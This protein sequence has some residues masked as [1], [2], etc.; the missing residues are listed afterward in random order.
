MRNHWLMGATALA[1]SL[2]LVAGCGSK[3]TTSTGT[4]TTGGAAQKG[5]VLKVAIVGEPPT[6]DMHTTT[7]T[8]AFE[9]GWHIFETLYTYTADYGI[10]PMLAE[11]LPEVKADGKI[12]VIKLR[13][14]VPFHNGKVMTSDDVVASINRWNKLAQNAKG[15]MA[16]LKAV[17]APDKNTVQF[18][19]DKPNGTLLAALATPGNGLAIYPKEI[20]D[21]YPDKP[22][23]EFIGTGPYKLIEH[24]PDR[25]YKLQRFDQY[26]S[27]SEE[28]NGP[29]GKKLAV[30]DE[31]QFIPVPDTNTRLSGLES[32]EYDVAALLS[33]SQYQSVKNDSS[34]QAIVV[35]PI[36]H[37]NVSFNMKQGP[38]TNK[39]VRQAAL[40]IMDPEPIMSAAFGDKDL[41]RI[42]PSLMQKE[43]GV[44]WTD[45]GKENYNQHNVAKA[46]QLLQQA[47]YKGEK[48]RYLATKEYDYNYKAALVYADQMK[49]AGFNVELVVS[50]W[51]T[52]VN[53]RAKP[54]AWDMFGTGI[55]VKNNP[56]L[57]ASMGDKW[58]G[59]WSNPQ[60]D[61]L[62]Q[63]IAG[64][65]VDAQAAKPWAELQKLYYEDVPSVKIGDYFGTRAARKNVKNVPTMGEYYFWNTYVEKK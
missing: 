39:L 58:F 53:N 34:L 62:A 21:K 46:K 56:L 25:Y 45:A 7:A 36:S 3:S 29:G 16:G 50:D 44:W 47:G 18:E 38:F 9:V 43:Q 20:C 13:Q 19:F 57:L 48:I 28:P 37:L 60:R 1:L 33:G 26:A 17:T 2:S 31:I 4:T 49:A 52:L 54:D 27:R 12:Y 35:K 30:A 11:T 15:A 10:Q 22:I 40:A 65:L 42:D 51:A 24:V 14:G 59:W 55:S 8:L 23:Q 5:G 6:I 32:G 61:Q 64:E 41:Y 63:Q